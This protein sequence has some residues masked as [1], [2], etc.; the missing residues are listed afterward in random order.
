[1]FCDTETTS[2][3]GQ[4]ESPRSGTASESLIASW[5][6]QKPLR[7]ARASFSDGYSCTAFESCFGFAARTSIHLTVRN[8][9]VPSLRLNANLTKLAHYNDLGPAK[10]DPSSFNFVLPTSN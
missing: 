9:D 8:G 5:L 4:R 3:T 10:N 7:T 2:E 1:M 6:M